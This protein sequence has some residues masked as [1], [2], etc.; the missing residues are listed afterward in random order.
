MIKRTISYDH[1]LVLD[2]KTPG[3][4]ASPA[5]DAGENGPK[6]ATHAFVAMKKMHGD[7]GCALAD[8]EVCG[9]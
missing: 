9:I 3:Q 2:L 8:L 6:S 1:M 4:P 5:S 7:V